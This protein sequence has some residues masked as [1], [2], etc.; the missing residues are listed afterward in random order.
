[1]LTRSWLFSYSQAQRPP[2]VLFTSCLN[3]PTFLFPGTAYFLSTKHLVTS[4]CTNLITNKPLWRYELQCN[5]VVRTYIHTHTHRRQNMLNRKRIYPPR[6]QLR[7][8]QRL[9]LLTGHN[10][11]HLE[12]TIASLLNHLQALFRQNVQYVAW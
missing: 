9:M 5:P 6:Y 8:E 1:M 11:S 7:E 4:H 2:C 12:D 3:L 10:K